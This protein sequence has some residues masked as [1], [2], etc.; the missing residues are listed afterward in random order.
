MSKPTSSPWR[1]L[2]FLLLLIFP[3]CSLASPGITERPGEMLPVDKTFLDETGQAVTL[4]GLIDRPVVLS[5]AYFG[6]RDVCNTYLA[7]LADTF[8]RMDAVPGKDYTAITISFDERD[9]PQDAVYKKRNFL[10]ASGS[11]IP[12]GAWRFLVGQPDSIK[13]VT[14]AAGYEFARA[15]EGF[16]HPGALVVLSAEGKIIRYFYGGRVLPADLEMALLEAREGR[17]TAS[18][19]KAVQFC[20]RIIPEARENFFLTLKYAGLAT[21][22][23]SAFFMIWLA[24]GKRE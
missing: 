8:G 17:V 2:F 15:Q 19:K 22:V 4:G 6:C 20:Y 5:F 21:L 3:A 11:P 18:I 24:T 7:N 1:G 16:N 23:F 10:K 9:T 13:A 12:D 14:N